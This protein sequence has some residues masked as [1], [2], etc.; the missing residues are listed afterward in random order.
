MRIL[1]INLPV[2]WLSLQFA[3]AGYGMAQEPLRSSVADTD[4]ESL[5]KYRVEII[6]FAY[7]DF[8]RTEESFTEVPRGTLVDL[9]NPERGECVA[10]FLLCFN[11]W[12]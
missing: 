1:R 2:F 11:C 9:L 7:H 10:G 3:V 8:D 6:A 5:Q 4:S 12:Q